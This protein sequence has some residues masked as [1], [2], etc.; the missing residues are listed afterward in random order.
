MNG[1]LCPKIV[2]QKKNNLNQNMRLI[3]SI[4]ADQ[5]YIYFNTNKSPKSINTSFFGSILYEIMIQIRCFEIFKSNRSSF[6]NPK[7]AESSYKDLIKIC[8]SLEQNRWSSL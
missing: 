1:K 4:Q 6:K 5:I 2:N 3:D 7:P 8:R